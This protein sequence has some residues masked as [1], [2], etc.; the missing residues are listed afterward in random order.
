MIA[1]A[2]P[3][4]Y[5]RFKTGPSEDDLGL[6][7]D[8]ARRMFLAEAEVQKAEEDLRAK[9]ARLAE[10]SEKD[11]PEVMSR[12]GM[13]EYVTTTGLRIKIRSDVSGKITEANRSAA[14]QW[15][16]EHGFG[17]LVKRKVFVEFPQEKESAARTL[18]A[19]LRK[20]FENVGED[21]SVHPQSLYAW[22]REQLREGR[23][24]PLGLFGLRQYEKAI[25]D[26]KNTHVRAGPL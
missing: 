6:L 8:L 26:T 18:A 23:E 5:S 15:L 9:K 17:G 3:G 16:D 20:K 14:I 7:A 4:D 1:P 11:I 10:I 13:Q 2:A 19:N 12:C 25:I 24:C 21:Y 22:A